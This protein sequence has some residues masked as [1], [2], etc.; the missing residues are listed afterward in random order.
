MTHDRALKQ[1]IRTH[2]EATGERHPDA[3]R[4][5]LGLREIP[6]VFAVRSQGRTVHAVRST[7]RHNSAVPWLIDG[8]T[9]C[10][11]TGGSL[12]WRAIR[13]TEEVDAAQAIKPR[14]D[15]P[16]DWPKLRFRAD[17]LPGALAA[18]RECAA[19]HDEVVLPDRA[20]RKTCRTCARSRPLNKFRAHQGSVD[21]RASIC[22]EC[23][24]EAKAQRSEAREK[25]WRASRTD[26]AASRADR[27][28]VAMEAYQADPATQTFICSAGHTLRAVAKPSWTDMGL[29]WTCPCGDAPCGASARQIVRLHHDFQMNLARATFIVEP[30]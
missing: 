20:T 25:A 3:R 17:E 19:I 28:T 8:R 1:A 2:R 10:G 21:G 30:D 4:Y 16:N 18:C 14:T 15:A 24:R 7:Q 9:L 5:I 23:R 22:E 11:R 27:F 12:P 6:D 13:A 29:G 26:E